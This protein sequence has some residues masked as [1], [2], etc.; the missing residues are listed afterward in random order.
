MEDTYLQN[1]KRI[2]SISLITD[3]GCRDTVH[4]QYFVDLV[5][6]ENLHSLEWKG[7]QRYD[8]FEAIAKWIRTRGEQIRSLT[9]DLVFWES[10]ER[11]W[12]RGNMQNPMPDNFFAST[13]LGI[14]PGVHTKSMSS[15]EHLSLFSLS[16]H[17]EGNEMIRAFN[18]ERLQTLKL[19]NCPGSLVWLDLIVNSN[20]EMRLK[21][22]EFI[23]NAGCADLIGDRLENITETI[24][25]FIR[26]LQGLEDL[27][28]M[29]P[30]GVD[31]NVVSSA[32]SG[33]SN[34]LRR[35]VTHHLEDIGDNWLNDGEI[36]WNSQLE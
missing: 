32:M 34:S 28:L 10:A 19:C 21:C 29:L 4:T 35:V 3:G 31:W 33:H 36:F 7:L 1:Q 15:L 23:F 30:Q 13:V 18:V 11:I 2:E 14:G 25:G 17:Y 24:T 12:N 9:L 20:K 8:D 5:Y 22:F 6:F 27:F 16:F 26:R